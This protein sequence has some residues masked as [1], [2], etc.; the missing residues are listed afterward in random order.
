MKPSFSQNQK[1][2]QQQSASGSAYQNASQGRLADAGGA[3][4]VS[5]AYG[6]SPGDLTAPARDDDYALLGGRTYRIN[7]N[8]VA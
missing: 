8:L 2:N 3:G 7:L 4:G 5:S 1:D 6:A